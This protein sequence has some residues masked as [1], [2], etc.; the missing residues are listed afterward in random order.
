[1]YWHTA[2]VKQQVK[3]GKPVKLQVDCGKQNHQKTSKKK[4]K[5]RKS[6]GSCINDLIWSF[7][8]GF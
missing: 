6:V 4:T 2:N 8:S 7:K 3:R 1:M 5:V